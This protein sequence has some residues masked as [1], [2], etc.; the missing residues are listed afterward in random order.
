MQWRSPEAP[1]LWG[2]FA[3]RNFFCKG[4]TTALNIPLVDVNHLQ[5]HVMAHFIKRSPD[6]NTQPPFP[7]LC[8]LVSGIR[9]S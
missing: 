3:H 4:F 2:L 7:F 9:K 1:D 5:A 8:L 6:D